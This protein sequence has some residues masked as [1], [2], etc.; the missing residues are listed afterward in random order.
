MRIHITGNAGSG[1]STLAK[2]LGHITG[3]P[4]H[5]LDKI[6]WKSGWKKTPAEERSA[7]ESRLIENSSWIIEG[8]SS[9]VRKAADQVIF[10]DYPPFLC[11]LRCFKRNWRYLFRSRPELPPRC[12]E[13]LVIS[14]LMKIIWNFPGIV[15]PKI[16]KEG[17][18]FC[19]WKRPSFNSL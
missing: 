16:L 19:F 4:V 8:V 15:R 17:A 1:K 5:S 3:L 2:R 12:P 9:L 13:I 14:E 7:L 18:A 6:V 10:L 11:T